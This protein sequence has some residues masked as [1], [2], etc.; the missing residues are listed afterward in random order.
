M[1]S[2]ALEFLKLIAAAAVALLVT[3]PVTRW[4]DRKDQRQKYAETV[5]DSVQALA[6]EYHIAE[7]KNYTS[8]RY[9]ASVLALT[10]QPWAD[11]SEALETAFNAATKLR[12]NVAT[13]VDPVR[14]RW[15]LRNR[16]LAMRLCGLYGVGVAR[17][18]S[19][20]VGGSVYAIQ[21]WTLQGEGAL[22]DPPRSN[23]LLDSAGVWMERSSDYVQL[24]FYKLDSLRQ[25]EPRPGV[26]P[27][28]RK[29]LRQ[30]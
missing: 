5:V 12:S 28:C 13:E 9:R 19:D 6:E 4:V 27:P 29:L 24:L 30:P 2:A 20:T 21:R 10:R 16:L 15:M 22:N 18:F 3:G 17:F 14:T 23:T 7:T 11:T 25:V 26:D 8:A 1:G